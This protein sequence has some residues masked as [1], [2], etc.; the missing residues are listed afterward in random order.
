[1]AIDGKVFVSDLSNGNSPFT[2]QL[3]ITIRKD[4][5][6]KEVA[7]II[8]Q[9]VSI[10]HEFQR[11]LPRILPIEEIAKIL[12][13]LLKILTFHHLIIYAR[14]IDLLHPARS[15]GGRGEG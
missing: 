2:P 14:A 15:P 4:S 6:M 11:R 1:M 13:G 10:S 5:S 12:C 8:I 9:S 7:L 3:R